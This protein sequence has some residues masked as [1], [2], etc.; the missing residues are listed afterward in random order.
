MNKVKVK[1]PVD[2]RGQIQRAVVKTGRRGI[3]GFVDDTKAELKRVTWPTQK[4]VVIA[5]SVILVIVLLS[6][7]F[8]FVVDL[9]LV[10]LKIQVH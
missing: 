3:G 6:T 4:T 9:G 1:K 10:H 5:S 2:R 7:G 8:V